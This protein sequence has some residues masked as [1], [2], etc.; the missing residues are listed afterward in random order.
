ML[1]TNSGCDKL[2]SA[3]RESKQGVIVHPHPNTASAA[4]IA[5]PEITTRQ[6]QLDESILV[7]WLQMNNFKIGAAARKAMKIYPPQ[8]HCRTI[9]LCLTEILTASWHTY[10]IK[11]NSNPNPV[12]IG[13]KA[14]QKEGEGIWE[15][16]ESPDSTSPIIGGL[17]N[18][19]VRSPLITCSDTSIGKGS[20]DGGK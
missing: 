1:S 16:I 6:L 5:G 10:F 13:F 15:V 3:A 12:A 11:T 17:G 8:D 20:V 19:L 2:I 14:G 4:V 7:S 18:A 9:C